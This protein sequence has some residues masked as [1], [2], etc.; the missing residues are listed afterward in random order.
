VQ[1]K[2]LEVGLPENRNSGLT[3]LDVSLWV[4]KV[5]SGF[6]VAVKCRQFLFTIE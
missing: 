2:Q 1:T 5:L 6:T 4:L 3:F